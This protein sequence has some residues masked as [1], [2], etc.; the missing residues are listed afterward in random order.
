VVD[1]ARLVGVEE[2]S[3]RRWKLT[4]PVAEME[5]TADAE[6]STVMATVNF[7]AADAVGA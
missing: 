6:E 2:A 7:E 3:P 4:T 5:H 1:V